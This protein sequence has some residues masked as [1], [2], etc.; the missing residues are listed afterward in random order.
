MASQTTNY[1]L[2]KID[3]TDAPPDITVLN[4][5]WDTIDTQLKSLNDKSTSLSK[6]ASSHASGGS[7]PI[8]PASIGALSTSGG[9]VN[10][11]LTAGTLK[12]KDQ[13][14][15]DFTIDMDGWEG[16]VRLFA[17]NNNTDERGILFIRPDGMVF[18]DK[19]FAEHTVIHS[20]NIAR[21]LGAATASIE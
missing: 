21:F 4:A 12:L 5:N 2:N 3:L 18:A 7:D 16:Y 20:G 11:T 19:N 9:T 13:N 10:G 8:T 17:M 6:H 15:F 1:K 14:G